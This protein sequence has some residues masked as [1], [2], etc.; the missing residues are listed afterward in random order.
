MP[1]G[2]TVTSATLSYYVTQRQMSNR[3]LDIDLY[4]L[5]VG[6]AEDGVTWRY[7]DINASQSWTAGGALGSLQDT[8]SFPS[9][10][11]WITF[12]VPAATIQA[13][14]DGGTPNNGLIIKSNSEATSSTSVREDFLRIASSE[15]ETASLR[16]KLEVTFTPSGNVLPQACLTVNPEV[17]VTSGVDTV[18]TADASDSDGVVT[19]VEFY[20]DSQL[21]GSDT[22]APYSCTWSSPGV[23][24]HNVYVKA[25]D[26]DGGSAS[27]VT[28]VITAGAVIYSADMD[29][30]PA[31]WILEPE[32]EHG[33]PSGVDGSTVDGYG[34]PSLGFT[35]TNIIGYQLDSPYYYGEFTTAKYAVT[36]A[37]DCSDYDN[38][39][40]KFRCW[41]GVWYAADADIEISTNGTTWQTVWASQYSHPGGTWCLWEF[42]ISSIADRSSL[43]YIR[44]KM[45]GDTGG[46][47]NQ[48][49]YSGWNIDD[50]VVAGEPIVAPEIDV[51]GKGLEISDGDAEPSIIDDTDFGTTLTGG[52]GV[53]H[54]FVITNSGTAM[55]NLT[56][57]PVIQLSGD[58]NDFTV[59]SQSGGTLGVGTSTTFTVEFDPTTIG[60]K[61][62]TV[63]IANND[64]NENPYTFAIRGAGVDAPVVNSSAATGVGGYSATLNGTLDD[65]VQADVYLYWG[66][67][68]GGTNPSQWGNTGLLSSVSEGGFTFPVS[69]LDMTTTYYY[70]F[71]ATNAA[72]SDWATSDSFTTLFEAMSFKVQRGSFTMPVGTL[73]VTLTN[74]ADYTLESGSNSSNSFIRIVNTR[75]MG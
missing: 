45:L 74:G 36:P 75:L 52:G 7:R 13:W 60:I 31:G 26:D 2:S 58:T 53:S 72:G 15:Y 28:D 27:S 70:N 39:T 66:I 50:V 59:T 17:V 11:G 3:G 38:V 10:T 40:L 63:S 67:T 34:E 47:G 56:G 8:Q 20:V 16:P 33:A 1:A 71:C 51:Y 46:W 9:G 41:L 61:S 69:G 44:W 55:L 43:V 68:D 22:N 42:D 18:L 49:A 73:T 54:V 64:S 62:A 48:Y 32:W 4:L 6:W 21:V 23:G 30:S 65:G 35:G 14:I 25:Y 5:T 29:S 24:N 57:S 19:N 37:I 12:N